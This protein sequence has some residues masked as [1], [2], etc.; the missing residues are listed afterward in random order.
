[1][2]DYKEAKAHADF[3]R[4]HVITNLQHLVSNPLSFS[5]YLGAFYHYPNNI[6]WFGMPL[7][8]V[9]SL[10]FLKKFKKNCITFHY[11]HPDEVAKGLPPLSAIYQFTPRIH[12]IANIATWR[13][14]GKND[15][16]ITLYVIYED[17]KELTDFIDDNKD[18][19]KD[20]NPAENVG[21]AH[22]PKFPDMVFHEEGSTK[23]FPSG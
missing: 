15:G 18:L 19:V 5:E 1:M 10:D 6:H 9:F 14:K 17:L 16:H 12:A 3:W 2:P 11:N 20:E 21:F 23:P 4:E 7:P 22:K 13:D 8:H